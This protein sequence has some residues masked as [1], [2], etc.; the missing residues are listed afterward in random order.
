VTGTGWAVALAVA[1]AAAYA[2][3]VVVQ[4]RAATTPAPGGGE[5][6]SLVGVLRSPLWLAGVAL[7]AAGF[8]LEFLALRAGALS[9]VQPLL[10]SGLLFA[11][12][13]GALLTGLP[14]G[15]RDAGA[16]TLVVVGLVV[17]VLVAAPTSGDGGVH[18][19]AWPVTL[20]V[21]TVVVAGLVLVAT[22]CSGPVA[23]TSCLAGAAAVVNGLLGAFGKSVAVR[24]EHGWLAALLSW[25]ALGL[26]VTGALTLTLAAAAFRAGAP[27]AAIGVLFAGEPAAGV[28]MAAVLHGDTVRHGPLATAVLVAAVLVCLSGVVVLAH[29]PAVL[30]SYTATHLSGTSATAR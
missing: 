11:L 26:L 24:S 21:V 6:Q 9:L 13:L 8:G 7:D 5:G 15:L 16:A 14:V 2:G 22:V 18:P 23:R 20:A 19:S 4:Q 27:T 12:A 25:P 10:V 29:S 3:G 30:A 1:A 28:V 17:A